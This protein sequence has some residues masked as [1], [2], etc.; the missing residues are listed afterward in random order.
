M[1]IQST[2]TTF[3]RMARWIKAPCLFSKLH[4]APLSVDIQANLW[5]ER[6]YVVDLISPCTPF[7]LPKKVLSTYPP[8]SVLK[9]ISKV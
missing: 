5:M 6:E 9:Q 4:E 1:Q 8:F 3:L 2:F 7:F